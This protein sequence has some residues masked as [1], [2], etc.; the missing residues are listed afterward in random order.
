MEG[1][2]RPQATRST[3]GG[4]RTGS[5][6][7]WREG[8]CRPTEESGTGWKKSAGAEP[9]TS[10]ITIRRWDGTA[11]NPRSPDA[12]YRKRIPSGKGS[13]TTSRDVQRKKRLSQQR[14]SKDSGWN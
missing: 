12:R 2:T 5:S 3:P 10:S 1:S 11:R 14:P 13:G 8:G 9:S 4:N 6:Q 7:T